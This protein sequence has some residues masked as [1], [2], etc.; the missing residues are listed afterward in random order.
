VT[1]ALLNTSAIKTITFPARALVTAELVQA[2]ALRQGGVPRRSALITPLLQLTSSPLSKPRVVHNCKGGYVR[3]H[4]PAALTLGE[5]T[6]VPTL[7][8]P[9]MAG[10]VFRLL[11]DTLSTVNVTQ[12]GSE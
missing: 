4:A 9:L 6:L 2:M 10:E 12:P 5:A 11:N 3:L 7:Q 8:E 1:C